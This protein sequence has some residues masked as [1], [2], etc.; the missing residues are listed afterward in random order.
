MT[1]TRTNALRRGRFLLARVWQV[2]WG[3]PQT[4]VGL[5]LFLA[6][7]GP[8]RC[9]A[10]RAAVVTR[11]RLHSGL[12][13]GMFIFVPE[14]CSRSLLAHEYGHTLQS[15]LLGPLYLPA[16]VLPSLVWAGTPQLRRYRSAHAFSYY[17]FY[18]ERWANLLSKRVTGDLPEGW[19]PRRRDR[20]DR[21]A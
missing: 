13:L 18:T 5:V 11:W 15:M 9:H 8:R 17:R 21:K 14:V 7:R 3:L 12:C 2:V 19:Y 4:V 1:P 20:G 6:L 16:I 10:Y